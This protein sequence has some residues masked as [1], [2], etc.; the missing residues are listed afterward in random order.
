MENSLAIFSYWPNYDI[1]VSQCHA[2]LD[3]V[4]Q[5][6]VMVFT[7]LLYA[8]HDTANKIGSAGILAVNK[9]LKFFPLTL[10]GTT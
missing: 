1:T 3:T 6:K 9:V 10:R 2:Q 5:T 8:I 4:K 7:R